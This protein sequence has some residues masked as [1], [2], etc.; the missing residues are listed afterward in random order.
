MSYLRIR[1]NVCQKMAYRFS[2]LAERR[3]VATSTPSSKHRLSTPCSTRSP[4]T[5]PPVRK[6]WIT[7]DQQTLYTIIVTI[8]SLACMP[9][10]IDTASQRS[11]VRQKSQAQR[12]MRKR[13]R[14][15]KT[16]AKGKQRLENRSFEFDLNTLTLTIINASGRIR[17]I[18]S[19]SISYSFVRVI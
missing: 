19:T 7:T 15:G 3:A 6:R 18:V 8:I 5:R 9:Y 11:N 10:T 1:S 16:I 2:R 14:N 13:E 12:I 4:P 17:Q